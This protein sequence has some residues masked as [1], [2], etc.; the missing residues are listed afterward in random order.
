MCGANYVGPSEGSLMV[1][2]HYIRWFWS[3]QGGVKGC[4]HRAIILFDGAVDRHEN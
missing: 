4:T 1:T 3:S 2:A